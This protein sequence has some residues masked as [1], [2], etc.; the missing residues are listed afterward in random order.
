[1]LCHAAR[2]LGVPLGTTVNVK[3]AHKD[4]HDVVALIAQK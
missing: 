1:M 2:I 3:T 4:A